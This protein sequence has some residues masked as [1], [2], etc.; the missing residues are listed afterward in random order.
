MIEMMLGVDDLAHV[1]FAVSPL[2]ETSFSLWAVRDPGEFPLHLRWLRLIR[3]DFAAL[4]TQVLG[5]LVSR[6][7]W[8]PDFITPRPQARMPDICEELETLRALAPARVAHD[9][10]AA[11]SDEDLPP[12]LRADP[13]DLRERIADALEAYWRVAIEPYW[14]RMRAILEADILHRAQRLAEGGAAALF[15][16]LHPNV[17]W[18]SGVLRLHRMTAPHRVDAGRG[19][20]LC[21]TLFGRKA[22]APLGD[23]P[24][25][26]YPARGVAT[27]WETVAAPAPEALSALIGRAK[28]GVLA[29]LDTPASTTMVARRL[30]V[31]PSAVSQHLS[32]LLATGLVTRA[33]VGRVVLYGRSDLGA[34][35]MGG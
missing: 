22:T 19:L 5:A 18:D 21:P 26:A 30:G 8:L 27:L 25:V 14:A 35:L 6:R 20:T 11:Y 7:R 16:G 10:Q 4:D 34:R 12:V 28:A 3:D 23:V 32:T 1:R 9:V 15:G 13:I 2:Q 31:T 33:R 17:Q 29:A 24:R